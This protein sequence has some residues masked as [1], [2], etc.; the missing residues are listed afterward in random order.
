MDALDG[1]IYDGRDLRIQVEKDLNREPGLAVGKNLD[2]VV[3]HQ[4]GG[5]GQEIMTGPEIGQGINKGIENEIGILTSFSVII[6][7]EIPAR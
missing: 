3:D 1:R 2:L 5:I 4:E 6:C 7:K